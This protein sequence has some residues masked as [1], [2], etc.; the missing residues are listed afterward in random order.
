MVSH[1]Y[2]EVFTYIICV[3]VDYIMRFLLMQ[4]L[5]RYTYAGTYTLSLQAACPEGTPCHLSP[6][7]V[8]LNCL[9]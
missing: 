4:S 5:Q 9:P 2:C 1:N 6:T 3:C 8:C 7:G